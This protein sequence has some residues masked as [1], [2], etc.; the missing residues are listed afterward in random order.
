M[1]RCYKV[2]IPLN[3]LDGYE[4]VIVSL[5]Q[6]MMRPEMIMPSSVVPDGDQSRVRQSLFVFQPP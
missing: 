6:W 4:E 1:L 3:M 2:L 5:E